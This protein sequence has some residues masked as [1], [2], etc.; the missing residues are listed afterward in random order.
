[1]MLSAYDFGYPYYYN[2][3][4]TYSDCIGPK[5]YLWYSIQ[6]KHE[7]SFPRTQWLAVKRV[8]SLIFSE[9]WLAHDQPHT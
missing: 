8:F 6:W 2:L 1:M 9:N 4:E 3:N 5:G 7:E